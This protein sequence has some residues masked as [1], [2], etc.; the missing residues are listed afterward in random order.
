MKIRPVRNKQDIQYEKQRLRDHQK[1]LEASFSTHWK[2][3]RST[4][5]PVNWLKY[6]LQ[7]WVR[8]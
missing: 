2:K 7:L 8:K 1:A 3:L 6:A 4:V 5:N